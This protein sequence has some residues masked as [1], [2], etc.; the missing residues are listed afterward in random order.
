MQGGVCPL[1]QGVG[2]GHH[3]S[4]GLH[5]LTLRSRGASGSAASSPYAVVTAEE[6]SPVPSM[7]LPRGTPLQP[8]AC[9]LG[10]SPARG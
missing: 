5:G 3:P 10:L 7:G 8:G 6:D 1:P 9:L 2:S 4:S